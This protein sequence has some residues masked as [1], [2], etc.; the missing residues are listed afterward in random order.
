LRDAIRDIQAKSGQVPDGYPGPVF[1]RTL[2][3]ERAKP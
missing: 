3:G 1:L 2:S